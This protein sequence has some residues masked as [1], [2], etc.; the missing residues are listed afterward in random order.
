[1]VKCAL[2]FFLFSPSPCIDRRVLVVGILDDLVV[3]RNNLIA[4]EI[5]RCKSAVHFHQFPSSPALLA[6]SS[7]PVRR[8]TV[9]PP[10]P[11]CAWRP[12]PG[13]EFDVWFSYCVSSFPHLVPR[14]APAQPEVDASLGAAAKKGNG[15]YF[16]LF[17]TYWDGGARH[18]YA[19][20]S[21]SA[22]CILCMGLRVLLLLERIIFNTSSQAYHMKASGIFLWGNLVI[23]TC[24]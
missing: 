24:E 18:A 20:F 13:D 14:V 6:S 9:K 5:I 16:I 1:M 23:D 21:T 8:R 2:F 19:S 11:S 10:N 3:C 4:K 15:T 22:H 17:R 7:C 12:F